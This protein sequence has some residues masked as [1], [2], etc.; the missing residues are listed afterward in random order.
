M[1]KNVKP[2]RQKKVL[3]DKKMSIVTYLLTL[4]LAV[5]A[6]ISQLQS[7]MDFST[8][9]YI[10]KSLAKNGPFWIL[11]IGFILTFLVMTFGQSRD[12]VIKSCVLVNPMH[13]KSDKLN[14]KI[15]TKA[16][17][18]MFLMAFLTIFDI[19][20]SISSVVNRNKGIST[21]ENPIST[22]AGLH[23]IDWIAYF[24]S[25]VSAITFI[26]IGANIMKREGLSRP[27]CVIISTFSIW[28]LLQIFIMIGNGEIIG[29][30]SEKIYIMLTGMSAA[31]FF[32]Y[33]AKFFAG[34]GKKHTRFWICI[35]GYIASTLA[36]V[37]TIPRYVMYFTKE[38]EEIN[39]MSVPAT[40]DIAL[41]FVT[42]S[43][44][45]VFWGSYEY[46]NMP[47]LNLG[48][49]R[50][51]TVTNVIVKQASMSSIEEDD[52]AH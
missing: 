34:F 13:L 30:Y 27:N 24:L 32:M 9:K 20:L 18:A 2:Y 26:S 52:Q 19:F 12:K 42:I 5:L 16:G 33:V 4:I 35:M 22:F 37:S 21:E 14:K 25:L 6:R 44:I 7:N 3:L 46:K 40:S 48:G 36:A 23:V 45:T 31:M 8:G 28:K 51:W 1:S 10:D 50:R 39:Q 17:P 47:K 15:T 29:V 43:I 38:Y 41:I 49:K 11:I